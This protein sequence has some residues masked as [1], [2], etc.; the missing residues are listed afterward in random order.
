[1]T[2]VPWCNKSTIA[3]NRNRINPRGEISV[4]VVRYEYT[5]QLTQSVSLS[6]D[7]LW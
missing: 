6:M 4:L 5:P 1:M 2:V 3:F 7:E